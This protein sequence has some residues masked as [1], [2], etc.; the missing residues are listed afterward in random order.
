MRKALND[1]LTGSTLV[2]TRNQYLIGYKWILELTAT[3]VSQ[4]SRLRGLL[5]VIVT[6]GSTAYAKGCSSHGRSRVAHGVSGGCCEKK[7]DTGVSSLVLLMTHPH[8]S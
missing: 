6:L 8:R 7:A 5:C 3:F 2:A 4:L 1:S